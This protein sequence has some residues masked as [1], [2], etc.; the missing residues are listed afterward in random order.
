MLVQGKHAQIKLC[1]KHI[2]IVKIYKDP[3]YVENELFALDYLAKSGIMNL[4]PKKETSNIISM[5][6]IKGAERPK[7]DSVKQR[8]YLIGNL[9]AYLKNLHK[10]SYNSYSLYI[11]HEDLFLDNLLICPKSGVLYFIDWGLSKKRDSVYPDIASA[12]LGIMNDNSEYYKSFLI[13]YFGDISEINFNLIEKYIY[14]SYNEY[15]GIRE[16]NGIETDSLKA[17]L[18]NAQEIVK[19]IRRNW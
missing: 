6:W 3:F 16:G 9:A 5:D 2:R 12:A 4:H 18:K 13:K 10:N 14:E 7:I 8:H 1:K 19:N 17:R 11:T 15:K